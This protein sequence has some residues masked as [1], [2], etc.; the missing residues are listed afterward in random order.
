MLRIALSV[1]APAW[2]ITLSERKPEDEYFV[3]LDQETKEKLRQEVTKEQAELEREARRQLHW[4]H[5]GKCGASMTTHL[6]RGLDIEVCGACGAVLLDDG[7]LEA[8]AGH[9]QSGLL[10][11][12]RDLFGTRKR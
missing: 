3:K 8:L 7:E 5:C 6:F 2:E 1:G 12:I 9:D 11:A 4:H 10:T